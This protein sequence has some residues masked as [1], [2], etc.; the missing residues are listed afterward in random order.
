ML[1]N[2]TI[3]TRKSYLECLEFDYLC[4]YVFI[5]LATFFSDVV[6]L[7]QTK[8]TIRHKNSSLLFYDNTLQDPWFLLNREISFSL[9]TSTFSDFTGIQEGPATEPCCSTVAQVKQSH[10]GPIPSKA[11]KTCKLGCINYVRT[12]RVGE[13]LRNV[14]PWTQYNYYNNQ[15]TSILLIFTESIHKTNPNKN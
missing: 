8:L 12:R 1:L 10:P 6:C 14:I 4:I 7:L 9:Q 11:Q 13:E 15:Y 5:F 2:I 3:L